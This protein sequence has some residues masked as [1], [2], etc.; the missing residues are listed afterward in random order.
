VLGG[1]HAMVAMNA[2]VVVFTYVSASKAH[3]A[4]I[5]MLLCDVG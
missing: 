3:H 1:V 2:D 4:D 5:L